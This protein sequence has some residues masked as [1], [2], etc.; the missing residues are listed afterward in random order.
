AAQV[1][2][3]ARA[4][5]IHSQ[6]RELQRE[7]ASDA[8]VDDRVDDVEVFARGHVGLRETAETLAKVIERNRHSAR[9]DAFGGSDGLVSRLSGDETACE[10]C[11]PPH[12]V[13]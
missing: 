7:V 3:A 5:D 6:L 4:V 13:P 8:R 11:R 12:S 10:A 9:L 1:V 2:D